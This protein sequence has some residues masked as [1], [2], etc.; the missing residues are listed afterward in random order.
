MRY[1][2]WAYLG[3][4]AALVALATGGAVVLQNRLEPSSPA[5]TAA[6]RYSFNFVSW[7]M[8]HLPEKWLYKIGGLFHDRGN[9]ADDD[10]VISRYF[11]LV[12]QI[13]QL[14]RDDPT[15]RRLRTTEAERVSLE[16]TVEDIIEGRVTGVLEDQGLT[17]G[18][19]PF[20]DMDIVFPPVD[21]EFDSS[22]RLLAVSPR[23]RI[24]LRDDYMLK[25]GLNR[26]TMERVEAEAE[27]DGNTSALVIQSGGV[28]TYPS[29]IS[30]ARSYEDLVDT[31]FHEWLHQHLVFYPLGKTYFSSDRGRTLNE[32]IANIAGHELARMYF[33]RYSQLEPDP[34]ATPSA[35]TVAPTFDFT[36]EMR[37]LR[38]Q[39]EESLGDGKVDEAEA[40][41][42]SKRDEFEAKGRY[43]RR[44]NQA[45]FAF[46]GFYADT[47]GSIDPIGP[48]LQAILGS[49]GSPGAFIRRLY[50]VTSES[51]LDRLVSEG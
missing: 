14:Q 15:S 40:L 30:G 38:I 39:V 36:A 7:E 22:L 51:D 50:G 11:A 18:P 43:I 9:N 23:D 48:K 35:P 26:E 2:T 46:H 17:M 3:T 45:Y 27:S 25:P 8:R 19:P 21:F 24:A 49:S 12:A 33:E 37:A 29:M 44:I 1:M 34:S 4:L 13:S 42:N 47:P 6:S 32:S 16:N 31:V 28:A 41:M 10:A 20:T 5:E